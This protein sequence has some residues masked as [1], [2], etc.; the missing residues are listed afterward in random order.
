MTEAKDGIHGVVARDDPS[1]IY[2]LSDDVIQLVHE[3]T[4]RFEGLI[5]KAKGS[6]QAASTEGTLQIAALVGASAVLQSLGQQLEL[7]CIEMA[8]DAA[9]MIDEEEHQD[10]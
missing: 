5:A 10:G 3:H 4:E 9:D 8:T 1:A 2:L 7:M 6:G